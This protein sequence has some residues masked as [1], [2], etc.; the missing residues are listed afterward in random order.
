[1]KSLTTYYSNC[2]LDDVAGFLSSDFLSRYF[3]ENDFYSKWNNQQNITFGWSICF[4]EDRQFS[5][6]RFQDLGDRTNGY[7]SNDFDV[8]F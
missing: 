8:L 7:C 2:V 5:I 1:M 4:G 3:W 6:N